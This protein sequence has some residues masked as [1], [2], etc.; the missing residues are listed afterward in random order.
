MNKF[1]KG[2]CKYILCI[3]FLVFIIL[4]GISNRFSNETYIMQKDLPA[5]NY[6]KNLI[7]KEN[8]IQKKV[9][10]LNIYYTEKDFTYTD[11]ILRVFD[12][13]YPLISSDF[14]ISIT[15]QVDIILWPTKNDMACLLNMEEDEVPMGAYYAGVLNILS[16]DL[17]I[18]S[19]AESDIKDI[20]LEEGPLVHELCHFA[21][22]KKLSGRYSLWFTEGIALYYEKKYINFEWRTDLKN[23]GKKI[24]LDELRNSF[25]FLNEEVAYRRSYDIIQ[26]IVDEKGEEALQSI[27]KEMTYN[28]F[29]N[30]YKKVMKKSPVF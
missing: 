4:F 15:Y 16:P 8:Y 17:W 2:D 11:M 22:D 26:S 12:V 29:E 19:K 6:I 13:Y 14:D 10:N 27:I 9:N 21:L 28:S 20:F 30:A 24:T 7:K 25:E 18:E 1:F 23:A 5:K 3:L